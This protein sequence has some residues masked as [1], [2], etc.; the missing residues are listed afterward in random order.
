M[1]TLKA[2]ISAPRNKTVVITFGRFNPPTVGHQ[3]LIDSVR[4]MASRLRADH[5]IFPSQSQDAKKNPL[6]PSD[7]ADFLSRLF[8]QANIISNSRVKT[9]LDAAFLLSKKFNNLVLVV[10]EDRVQEFTKLLNQ[11]NGK[12]YTF[13]KIAVVSAGERDPDAEGVTGMSASKLRAFAAND[14]FKSF[15]KGIPGNQKI[16]K[17]IYAAVRG[18]MSL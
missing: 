14:D 17:E 18:G 1:E 7:K 3:K 6:N 5:A 12:E 15:A 9:V 13:E 10:G 2:F 4:T 11:Y 8:P 16:A